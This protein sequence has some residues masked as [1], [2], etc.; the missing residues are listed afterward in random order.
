MAQMAMEVLPKVAAEIAKPLATIDKVSIIGGG[1]DGSAVGSMA[2]NVPVIMAKTFQSVKEA[3][4]VDLGNIMMGE[5]IDAKI[6]RKIDISGNDD[7]HL[8]QQAAV[9]ASIVK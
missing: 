7:Q 9:A 6:N 8:A 3:T 1:N 2:S 5:S 4:G